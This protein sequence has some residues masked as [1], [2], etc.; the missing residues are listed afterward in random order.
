MILLQEMRSHVNGHKESQREL[1]RQASIIGDLKSQLDASSD[2]AREL[3]RQASVIDELRSA[4]SRT[5]PHLVGW[6][7]A[8]MLECLVGGLAD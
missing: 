2:S 6:L 5:P 3:Q 4:V 1:H 7:L 8:C